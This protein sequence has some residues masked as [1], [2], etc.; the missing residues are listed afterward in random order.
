MQEKFLQH[1]GVPDAYQVQLP[2]RANRVQRMRPNHVEARLPGAQLLS[3]AGIQKAGDT[4]G[5]A[6]GAVGK[7]E[8]FR[9]VADTDGEQVTS[10]R[11][12]TIKGCE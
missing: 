6:E 11:D 12:R 8:R 9:G 2:A 7:R 4:G 1:G 5:A 10:K 3:D